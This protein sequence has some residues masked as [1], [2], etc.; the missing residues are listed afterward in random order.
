MGS[1]IDIARAAWGAELP[2]WVEAMAAACDDSS[3]NAVAKRL[4]LSAAAVSTVIKRTYQARDYSNIEQVVRGVL[5]AE[6]LDCPALGEL[7]KDKCLR[8]RK[9]AKEPVPSN[10]L[11]RRMYRACRRCP[12]GQ[13]ES[14]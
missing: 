10:P 13:G 2:D 5:M 12:I 3:Q 8:W 14:A 4:E 1:K 7:Q 9:R 11:R 6:T